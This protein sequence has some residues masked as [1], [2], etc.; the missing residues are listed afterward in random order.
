MPV[1]GAVGWTIL[2]GGLSLLLLC[3]YSID[4]DYVSEYVVAR[5]GVGGT[6][7]LNITRVNECTSTQPYKALRLF[8]CRL[9]RCFS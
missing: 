5:E 7:T 9:Q 2:P 1:S 8:T 6:L 4:L 3:L